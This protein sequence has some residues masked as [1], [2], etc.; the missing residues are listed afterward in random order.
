MATSGETRWSRKPG[1]NAGGLLGEW[2]P[3]GGSG[4]PSQE[5]SVQSASTTELEGEIRA[6]FFGKIGEIETKDE[7]NRENERGKQRERAGAGIE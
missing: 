3:E 4:E 5:G 2:T 7:G 6:L 1:R